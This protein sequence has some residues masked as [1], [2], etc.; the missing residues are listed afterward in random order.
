VDVSGDSCRRCQSLYIIDKGVLRFSGTF[1]AN[2]EVKR[3][4]LMM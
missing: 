3:A 2:P 1:E 4:H